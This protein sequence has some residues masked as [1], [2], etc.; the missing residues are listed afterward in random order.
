MSSRALHSSLIL[1][2][3]FFSGQAF[4]QDSPKKESSPKKVKAT[5]TWAGCGITKKAFMHECA[6]AYEKAT[7]VRIELKGG[8]ATLGIRKATAGSVDMGGSCRI[9]KPDV[10]TEEKA[11]QMTLIAWDALV[12]IAHPKNPVESITLEQARKIFLGKIRNW[13]EL[14]GAEIPISLVVRRGKMSGVGYMGRR[15]LF[16]NPKVS[17]Y[18]RSLVVRSSGPLEQKIE[19]SLG[20]F[21]LTGISSAK[22]RK[23]KLLAIDG[24]TPSKANI[25]SGKYALYRPLF[26]VTNGKSK[27]E[28]QAFL[29]WILSENGQAVI[30]KQGTVNLAEGVAL[31]E[32]YKFWENTS[33]ITNLPKTAKSADK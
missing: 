25:A 3:V 5:L 15:L 8:G 24:V 2:L 20:A 19:K 21:G 17:Y 9:C 6:K 26:L 30:S 13:K 18:A 1:A 32:K 4:A 29:K 22:K 23:V 31:N 14:G 16:N 7:G 10:T 28:V 11:A 12:F 27:P 33:K